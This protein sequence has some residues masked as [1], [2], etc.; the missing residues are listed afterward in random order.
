MSNDNK[1][2]KSKLSFEL[3]EFSFNNLKEGE[4][5]FLSDLLK[6]SKSFS[7]MEQLKEFMKSCYSL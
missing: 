5:K 2:K 7:D 1:K 4:S 3:V 6:F